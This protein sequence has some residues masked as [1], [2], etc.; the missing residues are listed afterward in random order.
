MPRRV[1]DR[2]R[3]LHGPYHAPS[4]RVGDRATCLFKDGDVHVTGWTD[5][6]ISWPRCLP[7]GRKGHPSLLVDEE[8]ARAIRNESAAAV[9]HWWGVSVGVV[10]RWRK[11]LGVGPENEGSRRLIRAAA[12]KG[13]DVLHRAALA[14]CEQLGV[15]PPNVVYRR[16]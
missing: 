11:A 7:V 1:D 8:L 3:L 16:R 13:G 15:P 2:V 12:L 6:P 9:G 5:A 14:K 4:L 10:W